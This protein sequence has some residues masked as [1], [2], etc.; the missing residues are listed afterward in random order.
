MTETARGAGEQ[1][2]PEAAAETI[3]EARSYEEPLRR[4]TEGVTWMIWGVVTAAIALSYS[5]IPTYY[6]GY[7]GVPWF[8]HGLVTFGWPLVGVAMTY[9]TWRIAVV[10]TPSLAGRSLRSALS[11]ALWLPL[12][13]V[14]IGAVFLLGGDRVGE[15]AGIPIG[16]GLAWLTLGGLN[17]FRATATGR[18]VM[19]GAGAVTLAGGLAFAPFAAGFPHGGYPQMRLVALALG[20][21]APFLGGLWQT[22]RG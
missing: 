15:A 5:S 9:A 19:L 3:E 14:G 21:G 16:I 4:R 8:L 22:L 6:P 20:G 11:S 2:T 13:Y 10:D 1:L 18:R 12:V 17:P 7:E